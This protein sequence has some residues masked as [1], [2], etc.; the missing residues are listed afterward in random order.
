[1]FLG[2]AVVL[3]AAAVWPAA[4]A[5]ADLMSACAGDIG[6]MCGDVSKGR[7]RISACLAAAPATLAPACR[8]EVQ[9]VA[10]SRLVPRDARRIFDPG[11]RAALPASCAAD[12]ARFCKGIAQGDGR[13]FACLYARE[14]RIAAACKADTEAELRGK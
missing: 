6:R 10:N 13:A 11:F 5:R 14:N 12:F 4:P 9:S 3:A 1:V 2:L 8:A 7:G